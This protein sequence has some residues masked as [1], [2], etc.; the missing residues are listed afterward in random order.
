MES[1]IERQVGATERRR[2]HPDEMGRKF[3]W[4]LG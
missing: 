3:Y 1:L 4:L 2:Q